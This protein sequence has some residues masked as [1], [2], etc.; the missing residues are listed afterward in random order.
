MICFRPAAAALALLPVPAFAA[1]D[2]IVVTAIG[3]PQDERRT[4]Q[5][6]TVLDQAAIEQRQLQ[7][8]SDLLSTT[9]GVTVSRNGGPGQ[10]TAVR[11]RGAEDAQTLVLIDGVRVNDPS[12]PAAAFDFGNLL[13]GNI[14]R[15]EVL[16]GPNSVPWGSQAIGGV[17]NIVTASPPGDL[18]GSVRGE[19]GYKNSAQIVGEA[20]DRVGAVAATIGGGYFR[21]D[22]VS[23][24]K[25][26]SERDGY[27][28]Y[29]ADARVEVTLSDVFNVDLR[30]YYAHSR[31][32]FDGFPPPFFVFADT[33]DSATT[34]QIVGY[35]ALNA[36]FG[37]FRD[38]I[39]FTIN[40]VNRDSS[41]SFAA[42]GRVE[43]IEYQG[44]A[45]IAEGVRAVFGIEHEHSRFGDG[46]SRVSTRIDSA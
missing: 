30:G 44:D 32:D 40:D 35:A 23:A 25:G 1:D 16:R 28:Q 7:T 9:P 43:R 19:Y 31:V 29:A 27:R 41:A 36:A 13:T 46:T 21:D 20:G 3:A 8:V 11:I 33:A 37:N 12:A 34:Q 45:R 38:R 17:V 10:P 18:S 24:F 26:G 14:E 5:S 22:G 39:A 4:G 6:I 2:T 42:R 15:I